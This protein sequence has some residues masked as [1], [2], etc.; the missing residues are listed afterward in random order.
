[1]LTIKHWNQGDPGTVDDHFTSLSEIHCELTTDVALHLPYSPIGHSRVSH[2]HARRQDCVEIFHPIF[3]TDE[4]ATYMNQNT[5]F[6][7]LIGSRICHD[8]ISPIGAINNGLE[9]MEM[10]L[11][12]PTQEMDL[13]AESVANASAR[14]RFFRIAFGSAD[15]QMVGRSEVVSILKDSYATSRLSVVWAPEDGQPRRLVRLALLATLCME[16]AMPYGGRI[17]ISIT[18]GQIS[19]TGHADKLNLD[20]TLWSMLEGSMEKYDLRPAQVQFGLLPTHAASEG[21]TLKVERTENAL[22]ITL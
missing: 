17:E 2:Q 15:T 4:D 19:L 21:H 14:I 11:Q 12:S 6:A 10:S 20:E 8:L 7:A 22:C 5:D 13:I 16:T 9:L 18:D 3:L 1:M